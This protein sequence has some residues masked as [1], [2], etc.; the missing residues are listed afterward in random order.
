[1]RS[2]ERRFRKIQKKN[3]YWS[4]YYC[5]AE[6]VKEQN[7]SRQAIH[8]WFYKLIDENDYFKDEVKQL[9]SQLRKLSKCSEDN[10]K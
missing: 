7:F 4:S 9:L 8:R 1:M 3:L 6:A 5:F 10:K 2:L